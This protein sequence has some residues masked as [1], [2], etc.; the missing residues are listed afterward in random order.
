MLKIGKFYKTIETPHKVIIAYKCDPTIP[1]EHYRR[2]LEITLS[3]EQIT[4]LVDSG[5]LAMVVEATQWTSGDINDLYFKTLV[6][7]DFIW[8]H[9][10][11]LV[12]VDEDG[13]PIASK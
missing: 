13:M 2:T 4:V 8:F 11:D 6:G 7:E 3:K 9:P 12:E 1:L 5:T 10:Y